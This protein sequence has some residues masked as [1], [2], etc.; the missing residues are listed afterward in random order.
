MI[1]M[2]THVRWAGA[3]AV[4]AALASALSPSVGAGAAPRG[5]PN[6]NPIQ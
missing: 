1:N 2:H 3:A 6:A 4:V 5:Y